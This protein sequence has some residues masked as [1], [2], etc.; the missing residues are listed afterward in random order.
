MK[1][2]TSK[3]LARVRVRT[4][5]ILCAALAFCALAISASFS[6]SRSD[7]DPKNIRGQVS[8]VKADMRTLATA[9]ESFYIDHKFYPEG[10][11][12][13]ELSRD[14][15]A[16][17][18]AGIGHLTTSPPGRMDPEG[19]RVPG[20][21]TPIGYIARAVLKDPFS[22]LTRK[23]PYIYHLGDREKYGPKIWRWMLI[24]AGPD[25]DYDFDP[26][27]AFDDARA[28]FLTSVIYDPTNGLV[29]NGDLMRT[30]KGIMHPPFYQ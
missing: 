11:A 25:G 8:R 26:T 21:S 7:A 22:P 18:S 17:A 16:L 19:R 3:A 14:R 5:A 28:E 20:L 2:F 4:A 29:S 9:I 12:M 10:R 23:N 24:S 30:E 6:Q 1:L 27:V 15:E 13:T